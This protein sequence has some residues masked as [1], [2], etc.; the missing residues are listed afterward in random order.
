MGAGGADQDVVGGTPVMAQ[1]LLCRDG[2]GFGEGNDRGDRAGN[3]NQTDDDD[4]RTELA[5]NGSHYPTDHAFSEVG[6][7]PKGK[8]GGQF[9][10]ATAFLVRGAANCSGRLNS[11]AHIWILTARAS[12]SH[13]KHHRP[14]TNEP[15]ACKNCHNYDKAQ[16]TT[17][18][19]AKCDNPRAGVERQMSLW[20]AA[21]SPARLPPTPP[22]PP[23]SRRESASAI[24]R[25][26]FTSSYFGKSDPG[27]HLPA[28]RAAGR[29]EGQQHPPACQRL[30]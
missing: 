10:P 17:Q 14:G 20:P 5:L 1:D 21:P 15:T 6:R 28:G 13:N 19:I 16:S 22:P 12:I 24:S 3:H 26:S 30:Q 29:G 7:I 25:S 9:V 23:A 2:Y 18:Y 8:C 27:V 4:K 11:R